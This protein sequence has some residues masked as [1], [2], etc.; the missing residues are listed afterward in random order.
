[1]P[2]PRAE[3]P[4]K[5]G[6]AEDVCAVCSA[7]FTA[8]ERTVYVW[9]V[10]GGGV[11]ATADETEPE[12]SDLGLQPVGPECKKSIPAPYRMAA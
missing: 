10:E 3:N 7:Y 8:N 12:D 11:I 9:V 1:M 5:R 2:L 4:K 6:R